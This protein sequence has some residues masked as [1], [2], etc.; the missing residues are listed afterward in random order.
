MVRRQHRVFYALLLASPIEWLL[1]G[2]PARPGQ[3]GA[4]AL[5]LGGL[6]GYRRAGHALGQRLTPL[7]APREPASLS[8]EGLYRRV[9]HPMYLAELVMAFAAPLVLGARVSLLLSLAFAA[10]IVQRIAREERILLERMPGYREYAAR[11][12]RLVPYVY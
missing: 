11:T 6:V 7:L 2:R 10:V 4:A 12:H 3:L 9:R 5:F 1:A 8:T